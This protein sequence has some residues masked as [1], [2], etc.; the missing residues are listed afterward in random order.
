[1]NK[2]A[3][4]LLVTLAVLLVVHIGLSVTFCFEV[5]DTAAALRRQET[6]DMLSLRAGLEQ[7]EAEIRILQQRLNDQA[8]ETPDLYRPCLCQ[9]SCSC[10]TQDKP[11]DTAPTAVYTL[12]TYRDLI[13]VF[14]GDGQLIR[15]LNVYCAALPEADQAALESGITV[16]SMEEVFR[17]LAAYS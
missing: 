5:Y 6:R 1:M 11:A 15:V 4:I 12:R 9:S 13:G 17:I 16:S 10:E 7:A 14:D 3:R 2:T 8:T